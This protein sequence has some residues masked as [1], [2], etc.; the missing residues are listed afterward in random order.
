RT[1]DPPCVLRRGGAPREHRFHHPHGLGAAIDIAHHQCVTRW[2]SNPPFLNLRIPFFVFVAYHTFQ[3]LS[4][5][6]APGASGVADGAEKGGG[7]A[8]VETC[9]VDGG[10]DVEA[11]ADF[12][13]G[14]AVAGLGEV[15][16]EGLG[17]G[18]GE[19]EVQ[20]GGG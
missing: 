7:E 20:E 16:L 13:L 10:G 14:G 15:V 12:A 11:G 1:P 3:S 5:S 9:S 17:G 8:P 6:L 18:G 19:E 2:Y 4:E